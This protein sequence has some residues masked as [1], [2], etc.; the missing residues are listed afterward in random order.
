MAMANTPLSNS[1]RLKL[2]P[3]F[4]QSGYREQPVCSVLEALLPMAR[5]GL[6]RAG[7]DSTES[8]RYLGVIEQRL[9]ERQT[10]ASWQLGRLAQFKKTMSTNSALHALLDEFM[11]YSVANIPVAEWPR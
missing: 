8:A 7:I 5:E 3:T 2:W 1:R 6:D 11:E 10:G 4:G 9:I